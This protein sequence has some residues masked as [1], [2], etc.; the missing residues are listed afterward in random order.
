MKSH[1]R[2][3]VV[4]G[5]CVGA[6][7][8]YALTKHGCDDAVLLERTQLTAGST[9]HAAGLLVTFARSHNFGRMAQETIRIY[10]EVEQVSG[11]PVGF[12][13]CGQLRVANTQL[14]MDEF[15]SYI[16][17]VKPMDMEAHILSPKEVQDL[18]PLLS[19]NA[20]IKGGLFHPNDGH[21]A[22]GDITMAMAKAA[23]D[24]GAKIHLETEAQ[25]YRQLPS[26]EWKVT[27]NNGDITCE[28]LVFATG[29]YA[30]EN[31]LKVGLELPA[32]PI[33]H[34]YWTT[35]P[36]AEIKD[37]RGQGLPEM[38]ILR[39]EDFSGYLRE[40]VGGLMF[41]PYERT[42]NLKLFAVDGVP[43]TFGAD[44]LPEDFDAVEDQWAN[45]VERI[46]AIGTVGIKSNVRGPFQMTPDEMPLAGPAW[47]YNNLWLAEGVPGGILWG[48][49]IG[50]HLAH[51]IL[52]GDPGIDMSEIDPRRFGSYVN[53]AWTKAKVQESWGTHMDVHVPGQDMP[54]GRPA[55]TAP[56]YDLLT[57]HGAVWSVMD[58]WE[59]PRWFAPSPD[60][61]IP[62]FG[63]RRTGHF[64]LVAEEVA[65]VRTNVGLNDIS[66]MA[67]FWVTGPAAAE[68][69]DG[70]LANRL[71]SIGRIGLCV[72]CNDWG[73]V[74]SE[75]TVI[76]YGE[77]RFYLVS[78]PAGERL[79]W[80]ELSKRLPGDGSVVMENVSDAMG[81]FTI[82][83]PNAR[84]V[85][86]QLTEID[87]SNDS[88]P[89]LTAKVGDVGL[90]NNVQLLRV[91]YTGELGWELHHPLTYQRH[92]LSELLRAGEKYGMR[93]FGLEALESLRLDKSYRAF[94]R[95]LNPEITALESG[96][97]RFIRFEKPAF[98]GRDALLKQKQDGV[99]R[100][101]VTVK[102]P[103]ADTSVLAHEAVYHD[104]TCV[105]R[106]TSGGYSYHFGHDIAL[107][108]VP[109]GLDRDGVELDV[110]VFGKRRKG[111]VV[112]GCLYDPAN[113]RCRM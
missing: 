33:V 61:A 112:D 79:N 22:P 57:A 18:F 110:E 1:A 100:R 10:Q 31:A 74:V 23:R 39:D 82:D 81:V 71:P 6:S 15:E 24:K 43:K 2:V 53:K 105:G 12:H 99:K 46:P 26:G 83:G 97:D 85:L 80:D 94:R 60:L 8:L 11:M 59:I 96:I 72:Q 38:P 75:Y 13:Q 106:V 54:R 34:Q 66:P 36:V 64:E 86:Q 27:T 109:A 92:I 113:E 104:G 76:R 111:V 4:G 84:N 9:W 88:F 95:D 7:I 29:N 14:R 52:D 47:G 42:D 98:I 41:G 78:T 50:E 40:E 89:W 17:I 21:I 56:A 55:K 44:L 51:W 30:R 70:I 45:A 87:L 16:S 62:E 101:I 107:A 48:G 37:R 49:T 102:L 25:S 67:K 20:D 103:G 90:A 93:L 69:L 58:G 28:H 65:A 32:I 91:N 63:F 77:N 3:V 5:G 19:P 35:E 108:L 68:W 73:G